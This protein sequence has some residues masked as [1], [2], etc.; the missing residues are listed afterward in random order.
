MTRLETT[1]QMR[2][3]GVDSNAITVNGRDLSG[4]R[5]VLGFDTVLRIGVVRA[6]AV[7]GTRLAVPDGHFERDVVCTVWLTIS[8]WG[9]VVIATHR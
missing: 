4:R 7:R 9:A 1:V 8:L 5:L 3:V 2:V 6:C